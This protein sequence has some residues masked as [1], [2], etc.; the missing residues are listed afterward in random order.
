MVIDMATGFHY[1][2]EGLGI[3]MAW[4][5]SSEN[6]GFN[7]NFDPAFIEKILTRGV[8][9]LPVLEEA[10]VNPRRA[11]AGLYAMT[12]DHHAVLGRVPNSPA[13]TSPTDSAATA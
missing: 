3:L 4:A 8:K 7:T 11:W 1:R 6:P 2:P 12:P 13:S 10:E 5:D 9:R